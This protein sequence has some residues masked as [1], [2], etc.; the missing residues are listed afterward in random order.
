MSGFVGHTVLQVRKPVLGNGT[1]RPA[2]G[3]ERKFE[4]RRPDRLKI[5]DDEIMKAGLQA[6]EGFANSGCL[7]RLGEGDYLSSI[8]Q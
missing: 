6:A 1:E 8:E 7:A 4:F 2:G 5:L 3:S